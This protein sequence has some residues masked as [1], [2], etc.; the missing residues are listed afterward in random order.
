MVREPSLVDI[1]EFLPGCEFGPL[2]ELNI[3]GLL[4]DEAVF[5]VTYTA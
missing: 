3:M 2:A 4:G 1:L 5:T